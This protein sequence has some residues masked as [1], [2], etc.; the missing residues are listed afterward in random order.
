MACKPASIPGWRSTRS[1]GA[2]S[3]APSW[4]RSCSSRPLGGECRAGRCRWWAARLSSPWRCSGT[5]APSGTSTASSCPDRPP[6]ALLTVLPQA[7]SCAGWWGARHGRRHLDLRGPSALQGVESGAAEPQSYGPR[8]ARR[9]VDPAL[10]TQLSLAL[11]SRQRD[12]VGHGRGA[13]L[14][15]QLVLRDDRGEAAA[16]DL[17]AWGAATA[18]HDQLA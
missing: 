5:R 4:P 1:P 16:E 18:D 2:S 14:D 10:R 11:P 13:Q 9:E 17:H 7:P 15:L 12:A 6:A 8:G 3:T